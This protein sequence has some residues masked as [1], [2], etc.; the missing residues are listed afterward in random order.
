MTGEYEFDVDT[1]VESAG[2]RTFHATVSDRWNTFAGPNGGYML[3]ICTRAM[4]LEMPFPDPLAVSA[5]FLR[6]PRVGP[7]EVGV[8]VVRSG[9]RHATA[10][11][12]LEQEGKEVVRAVGTFTDLE[13]ADGRTLL[14]GAKPDLP[15]PEDAFDPFSRVPDS[16]PRPSIADRLEYRAVEMP[17]WMT[18][19]PSGDPSSQFWMR[20]KDG[21]SADTL[22]L[23]FLVDAA[24]PSVLELGEFASSTIELTVY[25][26]ARPTTEWLACR[27]WTRYLTSGYHDEEMEIWDANGTL[28]AQ[29]RQLALL[30]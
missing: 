4:A 9:K 11:A 18:G 23:T 8:E 10:Q 25:V 17:G 2:P 7:A 16:V 22:A 15:A 29:A 6:P 19:D 3:A 1:A 21:R 12:S 28:V 14:V 26:R 13:A 5:Q 27:Q 24:A 20:F 30:G